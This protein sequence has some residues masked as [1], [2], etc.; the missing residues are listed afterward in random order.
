MMDDADTGQY[1]RTKIRRAKRLVAEY[2][3]HLDSLAKKGPDDAE[4]VRLTQAQAD[5]CL[6]D[7]LHIES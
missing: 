4:L 7:D 3:S 2:L 6:T 5:L 1:E